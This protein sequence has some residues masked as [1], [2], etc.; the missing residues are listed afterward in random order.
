MSDEDEGDQ[1]RDEAPESGSVWQQLRRMESEMQDPEAA[2]TLVYDKDR[3][4]AL[5]AEVSARAEK[6]PE[7]PALPEPP[8][9]HEPDKPQEPA[10]AAAPF[11]A[12][13][14]VQDSAT[15]L[16]HP[17]RHGG[18][19]NRESAEPRGEPFVAD[20]EPE[21][22]ATAVYH[23]ERHGG[24]GGDL[25]LDRSLLPSSH[26]SADRPTAPARRIDW[27]SVGLTAL[28]AIM[29]LVALAALVATA[30]P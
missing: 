1:R 20:D 9:Q 21:Q 5:M 11:V 16:Y 29:V 18:A 30:M 19:A 12:D 10:A 14:E 8:A 2:S 17:E 15:A 22:G 28:A 27:L 3:A 7:E 6:Q 26:L 24:G 23:P 13:D 4:K 25:Q